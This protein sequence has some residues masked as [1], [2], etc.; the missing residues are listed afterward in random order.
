[1]KLIKNTALLLSLAMIVAVSACQEAD[2]DPLANLPETFD[3][4]FEI[5]T[6]Q[7]E[8]TSSE[9]TF[10]AEILKAK[11]GHPTTY[12]FM[13]FRSGESEPVVEEIEVGSGEFSGAFE[14]AK[15]DLPKGIDLVVCA[16][17]RSSLYLEN[18]LIGEE[19]DFRW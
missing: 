8:I 16:Y 17:V 13:W 11:E 9:V 1:M 15:S 4:A 2:T 6:D 18:T 5:R 14:L 12:G 10:K 19:R 3:E 7:P